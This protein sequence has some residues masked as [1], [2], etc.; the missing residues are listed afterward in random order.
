M[1][2]Q[3]SLSNR[4]WVTGELERPYGRGVN[5]SIEVPD[6]FSLQRRCDGLGI[7]YFL[8]MEERWY[9]KDRVEV[10]QLQCVLSD[11]DG[12]LARLTQSLGERDL[13]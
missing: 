6:I 11:P 2:E 9:R 4:P 8:P 5:F 7:E 1:L 3:W 13:A 12:Y 10:G